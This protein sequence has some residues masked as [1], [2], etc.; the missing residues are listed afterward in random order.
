MTTANDI[1][2]C[3]ICDEI[4]STLTR[5]QDPYILDCPRCGVYTMSLEAI[6]DTRSEHI[7]R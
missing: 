7:I 4:L 3:S 2:K 6:E 1:A 5:G